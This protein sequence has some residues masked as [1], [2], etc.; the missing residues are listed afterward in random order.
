[1]SAELE[2][3]LRPVRTKATKFLDDSAKAVREARDFFQSL[4]RKAEREMGTKRDAASYRAA[5]IIGHGAGQALELVK[6]IETPPEVSWESLKILKDDLST[7]V[8]SL[9]DIRA[10][11]ASEL[12]GF[13]ILDMRSFS[14]IVDRL[15]KNAERLT[16]FLDGE[17]S[18][19]QKARTINGIIESMKTARHEVQDKQEEAAL[20]QR[21]QSAGEASI[22]QL[23]IQTDEL[24]NN[25]ELG[26]VLAIERELR[27]ESRSFRTETL[28]HLQRPMRRLREISERGDFPIDSEQR[29]ALSTYL[30][31]PYKSFLSPDRGKYLKPILENMRNAIESGKMEFKP[32]KIARISHQLRQLITTTQLSEKQKRGIRLLARR[33]E[34][35]RNAECKNMYVQRKEILAKI[36]SEKREL[37]TLE[38]KLRSAYETV[39]LSD[40]RL[41]ELALL[42]ETKTREYVRRE[43]LL[44]HSVRTVH[45]QQTASRT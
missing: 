3:I 39:K 45:T 30:L 28:A 27:K 22:K 42:A 23:M 11:T 14:G 34:L 2:T 16:A 40:Q 21:E 15:A 24:A 36:E 44:E 32:R 1:M 13:Y 7:S 41:S 25:P 18:N 19:L 29:E 5:R 26:E 12:S 6:Q 17:G 9:R 38:T 4:S 37:E 43:V 33:K 35:L 8:R 31:V 10:R 20:L